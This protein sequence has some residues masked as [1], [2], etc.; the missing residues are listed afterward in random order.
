MGLEDPQTQQ[1]QHG[2]E[3][4]ITV[5]QLTRSVNMEHGLAADAAVQQGADRKTRLMP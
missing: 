3:R 2:H 4:E 5:P 1:P